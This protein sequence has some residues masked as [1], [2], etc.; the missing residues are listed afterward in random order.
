MSADIAL[1]AFTTMPFFHIIFMLAVTAQMLS[2]PH[3]LFAARAPV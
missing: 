3:I 2:F 1:Y